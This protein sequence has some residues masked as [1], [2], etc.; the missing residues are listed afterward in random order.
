MLFEG[1]SKDEK[2]E[3]LRFARNLIFG[4]KVPHPLPDFVEQ[5]FEEFGY[6]QDQRLLVLATALPQR[7][8]LSLIEDDE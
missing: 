5:W 6:N 8:L 3:M 1:M 4:G 7:I 2:K